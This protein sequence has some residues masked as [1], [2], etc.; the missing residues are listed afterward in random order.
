MRL[1]ITFSRG[2]RA[3]RTR[4]RQAGRLPAHLRQGQAAG[5]RQKSTTSRLFRTPPNHIQLTCATDLANHGFGPRPIRRLQAPA[6]AHTSVHPRK[7]RVLRLQR[8]PFD[9][10]LFTHLTVGHLSPTLNSRVGAKLFLISDSSINTAVRKLRR[11]LR[12]HSPAP[13]LHRN[14]YRFIGEVNE[15]A[16]QIILSSD[17][18]TAFPNGE[19][20][21]ARPRST[22]ERRRLTVLFCDLMNSA[23]LTAQGDQEEWWA[24]IGDHHHAAVQAIERYGGHAGPYRSDGVMAYFGWPEAHE[25]MP[26][27]SRPRIAILEAVSIQSQPVAAGCLCQVSRWARL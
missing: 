16:S 1:A 25:N 10:L 11:V 27:P 19:S 26:K 7:R 12:D 15:P 6:A 5:N 24:A 18:P 21:V 23:A 17:L 22:G 8:I 2:D 9:L 13:A 3:A 4:P 20:K 14:H